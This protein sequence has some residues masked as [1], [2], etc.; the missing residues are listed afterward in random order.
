[1]VFAALMRGCVSKGFR[2]TTHVTFSVAVRIE[3]R[4]HRTMQI[5]LSRLASYPWHALLYHDGSLQ[6]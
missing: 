3:M 4:T 6:P 2:A 5:V 1:M